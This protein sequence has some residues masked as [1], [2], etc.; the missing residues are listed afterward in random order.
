LDVDG[1][2]MRSLQVL[3]LLVALIIVNKVESKFY[4]GKKGHHGGREVHAVRRNND[5]DND[6]WDAERCSAYLPY[7][8]CPVTEYPNLVRFVS[9]KSREEGLELVRSI[10]AG[11]ICSEIQSYIRCWIT[12]INSI[13][14]ECDGGP[15]MPTGLKDMVPYIRQYLNLIEDVCTNDLQTL[16]D[17]LD[18]F[19]SEQREQDVESCQNDMRPNNMKYKNECEVAQD[20]VGCVIQKM[21]ADRSCSRASKALAE[22]IS[23]RAFKIAEPLCNSGLGELYFRMKQLF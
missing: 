16:R 8:A 13:P 22:K 18:C 15:M 19:T 23:N 10:P 9:A 17:S 14:A 20:G 5:Y 2:K 7:M 3:L 1:F 11:T 4:K 12:F 21:G 6:S